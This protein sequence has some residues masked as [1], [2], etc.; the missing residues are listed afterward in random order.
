MY[1]SEFI[2]KYNNWSRYLQILRENI[3]WI[4]MVYMPIQWHHWVF[5]STKLRSRYSS[6]KEPEAHQKRKMRMLLFH[7]PLPNFILFYSRFMKSK[8]EIERSY[9]FTKPQSFHCGLLYIFLLLFASLYCVLVILLVNVDIINTWLWVE[10]SDSC[11][12]VSNE[13]NFNT[14]Y[15]RKCDT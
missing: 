1:Q 15:A 14:Q 9:F 3:Y 2:E 7:S 5:L 13:G 11:V 6:L 10:L 8:T 12:F 4:T